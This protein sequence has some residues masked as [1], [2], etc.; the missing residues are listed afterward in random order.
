MGNLKTIR[1]RIASVHNTKKITKAMN[2]VSAAKLRK[3][4]RRLLDLRPY[5]HGLSDLIVKMN[6]HLQSEHPFYSERKEGKPLFVFISADKGL[7]GSFNSYVI[8]RARKLL[9][10]N[11]D[12]QSVLIGKNIRNYFKRFNIPFLHTYSDVFNVVT[13][14]IAQEIGGYLAD[15]YLNDLSISKI[16]I[17]YNRF[18]N[19]VLSETSEEQFLPRV[20]DIQETKTIYEI[21][22]DAGT[23]LTALMKEYL[24]AE[25]LRILLESLTSEHGARMAAMD[26]ATENADEMIRKLTLKANRERQSII[27]T[28]ISEIVGGANAL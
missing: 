27:T 18:K 6:Y 17:V 14:D 9:A 1:T 12:S 10:E 21:E 16:I 24:K 3:S 19:S 2:M 7:C 11:P 23:L 26:A 15:L 8:R 25:V 4:E 28:E 20:K 13:F 22:P 5:A